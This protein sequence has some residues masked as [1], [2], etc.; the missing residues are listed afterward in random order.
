[1][2]L[3]MSSDSYTR[4]VESN[5]Y[6]EEQVLLSL[7]MVQEARRKY[8]RC[9]SSSIGAN[10]GR[11]LVSYFAAYELIKRGLTPKGAEK[12]ELNLLHVLTAGGLAGMAMVSLLSR[13]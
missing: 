3:S 4:R 2:D 11:L 8:F 7:E 6:S 5:Q 9:N 12:A 10:H 1:M 13:C